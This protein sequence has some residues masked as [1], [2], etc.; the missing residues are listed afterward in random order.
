MER[1]DG[2]TALLLTRQ[3][4]PT[5]ADTS[6]DGVLRG[7]QMVIAKHER[8]AWREVRELERTARGQ[9]GFGSTGTEG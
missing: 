5:L 6:A 9:G 3:G 7:A 4:L 1:R 2:P 8:A